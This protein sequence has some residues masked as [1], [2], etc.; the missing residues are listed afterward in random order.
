MFMKSLLNH[1]SLLLASLT[2]VSALCCKEVK[3]AVSYDVSRDFSL[4]SNP[5]G[6][7]SYGWETNLGGVFSLITVPVTQPAD[8]G[9]QVLS[10]Q[11]T[12]FSEPAV[13]A[14]KTTN[15]AIIAGGRGV[16]PPGTVW[17]YPGQDGTPQNFGIIRFTLQGG[18]GGT[19][20]V[21]TEVTR[22]LC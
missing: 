10:W 18:Q 22:Y 3:A 15:T 21:E 4:A 19:Y 11:L 9:V 17:F 16:Y 7:W 1:T 14:N 6:A 13:F 20:R 2:T 12:R 8:N 5:N